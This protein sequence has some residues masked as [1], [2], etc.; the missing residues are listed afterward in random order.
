MQR[1]LSLP[2]KYFPSLTTSWSADQ[3]PARLLA[4]AILERLPIVF[5]AKPDG[6][7]HR[8]SLWSIWISCLS[9]VPSRTLAHPSLL[10]EGGQ[11]EKKKKPGHCLSTAQQQ[12]QLH[13]II[14]IILITNLKHRTTW[15]AL[16]KIKFQVIL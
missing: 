10:A 13:C 15:A 5:I 14:N 16:N 12:S 2:P 7:R 6:T 11:N 9:C 8:K 3:C 1:H 4:M